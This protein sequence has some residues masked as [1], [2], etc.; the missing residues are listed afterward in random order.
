M[1]TVPA[2]LTGLMVRPAVRYDWWINRTNPFND[3]SDQQMLT[4]AVDAIVTF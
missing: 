2:P 1:P 3:S 4:A